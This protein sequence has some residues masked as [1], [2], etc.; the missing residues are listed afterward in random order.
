MLSST[1]GRRAPHNEDS[2]TS[3]FRPERSRACTGP[4]SPNGASALV[5]TMW[6]T[7]TSTAVP[8]AGAQVART[9][10]DPGSKITF[11]S[12]AVAVTR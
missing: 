3:R 10:P 1:N 12:L 6:A 8:S 5:R 7:P 2:G 9:T 4:E 11:G